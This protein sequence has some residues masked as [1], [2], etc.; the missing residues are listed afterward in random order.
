MEW[1]YAVII[2]CVM[3][4][5][6][7]I[8]LPRRSMSLEMLTGYWE[9]LPEFCKESGLSAAQFYIQ[10]HGMYVFMASGSNVL[11][12]KPVEVRMSPSWSL[13]SAR[14][15]EFTFSTGEDIY[16]LPQHFSVKLDY[17]GGVL[18]FYSDDTL[19]M[20]LHKDNLASAA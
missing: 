13:G 14:L 7:A 9:A 16:P 2:V 4:V 12:D 20:E 19:L 3:V 18:A 5:I 15:S 8:E 1:H 6:A 11:I 17:V 10:P